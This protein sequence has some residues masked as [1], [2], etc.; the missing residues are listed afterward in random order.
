MLAPHALGGGR[1]LG[2]GV[3]EGSGLWGFKGLGFR[4]IGVRGLR[5]KVEGFRV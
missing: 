4:R 5:L 2:L 3:F 1:V